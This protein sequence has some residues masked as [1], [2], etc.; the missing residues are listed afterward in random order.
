M[1]QFIG[2]GIIVALASVTAHAETLILT[3]PDGCGADKRNYEFLAS[4]C[5]A[6]PNSRAWTASDVIRRRL[7]PGDMSRQEVLRCEHITQW[8]NLCGYP[9]F[10]SPPVQTQQRPSQPSIAPRASPPPRQVDEPRIECAEWGCYDA[11]YGNPKEQQEGTERWA[12]AWC[13]YRLR[14]GPLMT[15]NEPK[16]VEAYLLKARFSYA[17]RAAAIVP[18]LDRSMEV[19]PHVDG[20][21]APLRVKSSQERQGRIIDNCTGKVTFD[22]PEKKGENRCPTMPGTSDWK[23]TLKSSCKAKARVIYRLSYENHDGT[24]FVS[25][26][27]P[28]VLA[29]NETKTL[30]YLTACTRR[31]SVEV[32]DAMETR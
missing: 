12:R 19:E 28:A 20:Q 21:F 16:C 7:S 9:R 6:D 18:E 10:N 27:L 3:R 30:D 8:A 1:K 4:R 15:L 25:Y 23:G 22:G 26:L 31:P 29:P 13:S 5:A 17:A 14:N 2:V 11:R 24:K 32:V